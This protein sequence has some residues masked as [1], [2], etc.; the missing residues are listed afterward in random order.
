MSRRRKNIKRKNFPD[1]LYGDI[2]VG[3]FTNI[4]MKNGKKS[5]AEKILYKAFTFIKEQNQE[6]PLRI[7]KMA[8][9][10]VRPLI[11]VK[12]RRVGGASYQVPIEVRNERALA[13]SFRWIRDAA[14]NRNDKQM[15]IS[16][17]YEL[18]DAS[19]EKGEAIKKKE[20]IHKM[21]EANKA[22]AHYRW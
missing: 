10:R 7:F 12:S 18:I 13:L 17:A 16:L 19:N 2:N 20:N 8:V 3:K 15:Y 9:E 11:E 6:D 22:F 5:I 21:A 14:K 4:I 1:P